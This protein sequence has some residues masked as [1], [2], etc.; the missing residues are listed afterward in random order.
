MRYRPSHFAFIIV[1]WHNLCQWWCT[2]KNTPVTALWI[3]ENSNFGRKWDKFQIKAQKSSY[4][5]FTREIWWPVRETGR[6]V[7]Y[8]GELASMQL[9]AVL[10]GPLFF[11]WSASNNLIMSVFSCEYGHTLLQAYWT[12]R[13]GKSIDNWKK[14]IRFLKFPS[15]K[16]YSREVL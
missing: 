13:A 5:D 15:G 7:L 9:I 6:S 14:V 3:K 10:S 2:C 16:T 12:P 11:S 1:K 4:L 8:L